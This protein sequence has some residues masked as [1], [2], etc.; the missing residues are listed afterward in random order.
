WRGKA[1]YTV[2]AI[3]YIVGGLLTVF[4]P[5]AA[6]FALTAML[7]G[8]F[9]GI[10]VYR[11]I[12]SLE[13]KKTNDERW[14]VPAIIGII[15]ILVAAAIMM[16]MPWTALWVIGLFIALELIMNGA[17]LIGVALAKRKQEQQLQSV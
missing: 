11:I 9:L 12:V 4:N 8:V 1:L 16:G 17:I 5:I 6:S 10:G 14:Y 7:A 15:D 2:T 13:Y 3:L